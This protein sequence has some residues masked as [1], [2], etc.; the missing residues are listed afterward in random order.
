M[1][2]VMLDHPSTMSVAEVPSIRTEDVVDGDVLIRTL[3]TGICGSDLP[4]F[5]GRLAPAGARARPASTI[6]PGYPAHEVVGEVITSRY[7]GISEGD[8][9]VGWATSSNGLAE[10]VV[11]RGEGLNSFSNEL[12]AAEAVVLQPLACVLHALD[13]LDVRGR[14][15]AILGLGPIGVMFAHAAKSAGAAVVTG[16][17]P[18]DR[19]DIAEA[20]GLDEVVRSMSDRWALDLGEEQRPAVIIE[21]VGHQS[22]TLHD[23]IAGVAAHGTVFYFGIPDEPLST[24]PIDVF[25]RQHLTLM[26]GGTVDR[27]RWLHAAD[28]YVAAHPGILR[29]VTDVHALSEA[30]HAYEKACVPTPGRLKIVIEISR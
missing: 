23:A 3:A 10:Y 7:Q 5:R 15:V 11:T 25:L 30:Q 19:S 14:H 2:A 13:R 22:A 4:A 29:C 8:R 12:G 26:A 28:R 6:I 17:D 16:I 18:V 9:V 24:F 1:R 21:A 20:F 27:R